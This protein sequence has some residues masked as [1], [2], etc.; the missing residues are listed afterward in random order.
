MITPT[1]PWLSRISR[2]ASRPSISGIRMSIRA[3]SGCSLDTRSS[4]YFPLDASPIT[5]MPS[6][7]SRYLRRPCLTSEWSSAMATLIVTAPPVGR[8]PG[9]SYPGPRAGSSRVALEQMEPVDEQDDAHGVARRQHGGDQEGR[10]S[11]AEPDAGETPQRGEDDH[12]ETGSGQQ[13]SIPVRVEQWQGE[14]Q[15]P[16]GR[17]GPAERRHRQ[18]EAG[19]GQPHDEQFEQ[20]VRAVGPRQLDGVPERDPRRLHDPPPVSL[21]VERRKRVAVNEPPP[22][23]P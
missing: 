1:V 17:L 13:G 7:M 15:D 2:A 4:S 22:Q 3:M 21:G 14:A 12:G 16:V 23:E 19:D 11:P 5:S 9:T 18:R 6:A 10:E 8:V 20:P